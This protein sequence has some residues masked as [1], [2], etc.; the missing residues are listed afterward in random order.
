MKAG[1]HQGKGFPV[2]G[3]FEPLRVWAYS[4][5]SRPDSGPLRMCRE[6]AAGSGVR[7]SGRQTPRF[8]PM[9][10]GEPNER[11][12]IWP[13]R[14]CTSLRLMRCSR[15][16]EPQTRLIWG[17]N[18]GPLK[19]PIPRT[20]PLTKCSARFAEGRAVEVFAGTRL[21][22]GRG[23]A[24]RVSQRRWSVGGW[25]TLSRDT[26]AK[27]PR[28]PVVGDGRS[29]EP[30]SRL[31]WQRVPHR[32]SSLAPQRSACAR[33]PRTPTSCIPRRAVRKVARRRCRLGTP[34]SRD[35]LSYA[36]FFHAC[37]TRPAPAPGAS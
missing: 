35:N 26:D 23:S 19:Q 17:D 36:Q 12:D 4:R 15:S 10:G 28:R 25:L 22:F 5:C 33:L 14:V 24:C 32:C 37:L 7:K 13:M 6:P 2:R 1:P 29:R 34:C 31:Q 20:A 8:L 21:S 3:V 11:V 27:Y 16:L 30:C 18:A 9:P